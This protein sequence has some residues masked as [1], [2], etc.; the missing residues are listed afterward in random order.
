M[1]KKKQRQDK[2]AQEITWHPLSSLPLIAR[3]I[4]DG[5]RDAESQEKLLLEGKDKPYV[6]DD[7][8]VRRIKRVHSEKLDFINIYLEQIERWKK[9]TLTMD[10][11]FELMRLIKQCERLKVL[12]T[13]ILD[14]A[15]E[16]GKATIDKI[17]D[18]DDAEVGLRFLLGELS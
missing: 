15:E 10:Q 1:K 13:S 7:D 14:L 6:F 8:M 2:P 11:N 9:E 16:I 5:V 18:M 3:L 12:T 4:D 17:M